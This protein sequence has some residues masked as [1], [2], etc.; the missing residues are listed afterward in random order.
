MLPPSLLNFVSGLAAGA[1]INLL[2]GLSGM[3]NPS[4]VPTITDSVI[5]VV[6][7]AFMAHAAHLAE[8][9]D[10][11]ASLVIDNTLTQ[12][13][14]SAVIDD[15]AFRVRWPYRVSIAL[16]GLFLLAAVLLIPGLLR[17]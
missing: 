16:S 2:T 15:E 17:S 14:R 7:A 4:R 1:G 6:D 8:G 3:P 5:W 10:R 11:A 9:A 13:E 12:D